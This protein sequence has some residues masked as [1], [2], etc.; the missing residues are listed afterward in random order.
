MSDQ[1][2]MS[3]RE[4]FPEDDPRHHTIKL[5]TMLREVANHARQDVGK[6]DDPKAKALFEV[7]AEVV[8][9]LVTAFEHFEQRTEEA[10]R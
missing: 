9:G 6:V 5:K 1:E 2:T 7:T 8:G 4:K 3:D 10:W